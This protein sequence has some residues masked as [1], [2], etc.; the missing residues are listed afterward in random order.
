MFIRGPDLD[1]YKKSFWECPECESENDMDNFYCVFCK[2]GVD[3]KIERNKLHDRNFKVMISVFIFL[4]CISL[5]VITA[6]S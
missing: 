6:V 5:Y 1:D 2:K 3:P 4:M